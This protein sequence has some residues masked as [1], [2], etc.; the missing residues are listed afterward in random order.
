M[1]VC[2][3]VILS[4]CSSQ[5]VDDV[6]KG[7]INAEQQSYQL[8]K[9]AEQKKMSMVRNL[10]KIPVF[11]KLS[12]EPRCIFY[13]INDVQFCAKIINQTQLQFEPVLI[14]KMPLK[15]SRLSENVLTYLCTYLLFLIANAELKK[16]T[17]SADW[18][19]DWLCF[20]PGFFCVSFSTWVYSG[21]ARATTRS[22][23][24]T[25]PATPGAKATSSRPL[26]FTTSSCTPAQRKGHWRQGHLT[27][28]YTLCM[29][30]RVD[31]T[32]P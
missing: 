27:S 9:L 14:I 6:K 25:A 12:F 17:S 2:F 22:S 29:S 26:A 1:C 13:I 16:K 19:Q 18:L 4:V 5:A 30:S 24:R 28:L 32:D 21:P 15:L 31:V 11:A 7:F 20:W 10:I 3:F 8:Q 23:S